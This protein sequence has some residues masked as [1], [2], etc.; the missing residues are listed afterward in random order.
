MTVYNSAGELINS[1]MAP[2]QQVAAPFD[3]WYY[4]DGTNN[5]GNQVASG[6][7][8]IEVTEPYGTHLARVALI[9]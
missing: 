5:S 7:Y 3:A 9:K 6:I 8:I 1:K 2:L 4:W